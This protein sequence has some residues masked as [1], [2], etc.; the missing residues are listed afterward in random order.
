MRVEGVVAGVSVEVDSVAAAAVVVVVV[1]VVMEVEDTS[2]R[3]FEQFPL[4]SNWA[5]QEVWNS[6]RTML[7]A[8]AATTD[9]ALGCSSNNGQCSRLQ[10]QRQNTSVFIEK[11]KSWIVKQALEGK[12]RRW[13]LKTQLIVTKNL[14]PKS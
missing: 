6:K 8:A 13:K 14:A 3:V 2:K 9:N 10:Q 1:V 7:S 5:G 11:S 4:R 12:S